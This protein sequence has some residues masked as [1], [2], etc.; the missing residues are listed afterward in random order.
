[1]PALAKKLLEAPELVRTPLAKGIKK[2]EKAEAP[3]VQ[4]KGGDSKAGIIRGFSVITRGEALGHELWIDGAF[5]Q[6]VSDSINASE[7]GVKARFTH[8]GLS[9]DG[10]GKFLGRTKNAEVDGDSVRADQHF[11]ASA[12]R[13]PDGD[14]AGYV[15]D[16]AEEDPGSFGA[17]IV[18]SRDLDAEDAFIEANGGT[19]SY[20][21]D[22][23][24]RLG[25]RDPG[26]FV[27]PDPANVNNYPH[28][29]LS[30]LHAVDAVDDP[31]ANPRGLFH[32]GQDVAA[33]AEA[34]M[35]YSLGLSEDE[36]ESSSF[37]IAPQRV[38]AFIERFLNRHDLEI[39]AKPKGD[40]M[41]EEQEKT[42]EKPAEAASQETPPEAPAAE[43][44]KP[45]EKPAEASEPAVSEG[46]RFLQAFGAQGGVWFAEGKSFDEARDLHVKALAEDNAA[47]RS[48]VDDLRKQLTAGRGEVSPV[49]FSAEQT[50]DQKAAAELTS[51]VGSPGLATFAASLRKPA[52]D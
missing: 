31:A 48:Q 16:R 5:L 34:L 21:R 11:S 37:G 9:S 32:R 7:E 43:P 40:T 42:E 17:S 25:R 28:A 47:L 27:S 18:F 6:S 1:M 10:L 15:M 13:T 24:K 26:R 30:A 8:P 3:A 45:A 12:H 19:V 41:P 29:R 49:T 50:E 14:L 46:K 33:E 22:Q 4:R 52:K 23:A 20:S 35:A 36:P 39:V 51:K 2:T 44:A 38:Q